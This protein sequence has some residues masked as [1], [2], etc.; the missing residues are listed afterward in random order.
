[1]EIKDIILK[2]DALLFY[3]ILIIHQYHNL[4]REDNVSEMTL[5]VKT[6]TFRMF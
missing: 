2:N 6:F 5:S 3:N 1:M 4:N